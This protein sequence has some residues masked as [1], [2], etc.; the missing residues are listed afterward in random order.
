MLTLN[1][2]PFPVLS[3]DGFLLRQQ[4]TDDIPALFEMRSNPDVM[5]FVPRPIAKTMADAEAVYNM[6]D[7]L[8]QKNEAI[9]WAISRVENPSIYL[10]LIGLFSIMAEDHKTEIGYMLPPQYWGQ[11]IASAVL[12]KVMYFAFDELKFHRL[13]ATIDPEN[14]AS[15]RI[16]EKNGFIQEAHLRQNLLFQGQFL[17]AVIFGKLRLD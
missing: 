14:H 12:P 15:R 4:T 16:L 13:E 10:G 17:D 6:M 9:N 5:R 2:H 11:G 8:W 1:F 7:S 3:F